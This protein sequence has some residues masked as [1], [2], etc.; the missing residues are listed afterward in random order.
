MAK[1][2]PNNMEKSR[3]RLCVAPDGFVYQLHPNT[4]SRDAQANVA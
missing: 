2:T 3:W 4:V 1:K